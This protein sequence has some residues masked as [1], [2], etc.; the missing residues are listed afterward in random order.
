[1]AN[2]ATEN[3]TA[4]TSAQRDDALLVKQ[5]GKPRL[6]QA[7]CG[8]VYFS[9]LEWFVCEI[10]I[11]D[12][13]GSNAFALVDDGITKPSAKFDATQSVSANAIRLTMSPSAGIVGSVIIKPSKDLLG[14][15]EFGPSV[16]VDTIAI[17]VRKLN[18]NSQPNPATETA[19]QAGTIHVLAAMWPRPQ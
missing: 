3:L 4:A 14:L 6:R 18:D 16:L 8:D 15:Y 12:N 2:T 17:F 7:L 10:A 19:M 9:K 11:T 5:D 13:A 1:M